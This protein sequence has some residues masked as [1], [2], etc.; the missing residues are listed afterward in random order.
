VRTYNLADLFEI[1]AAVVP[2]RLALVAGDVRLTYRDLDERASRLA[3]ALSDRGIA[4]GEHVAILSYNRAEWIEAMLAAYKI[5][6]VPINVNYRYVADELHYVLENSDSVAVVHEPEFAPVLQEIAPRVKG[7]KLSVEIGAEY[8]AIIASARSEGSPS[9]RSSDDHYIL[10]TGGTTGLPKG[11]VWRHEDIFFGALGGGGFGLNPITT[12]EELAGRAL[13]EEVRMLPLLTAPMMH[14]GGQWVSMITFYG[15]GTVVLYTGHRFDPD[16]IWR[17]VERE[18]CNQVMVVGDA[19]ARPLAEALEGGRYDAS[20]VLVI[21]SGGAILSESVRA[22]LLK[23]LPN[24]TIWDGFGTSETGAAGQIV[25][26]AGEGPKLSANPNLSVLDDEL[27][28]ATPGVI[29]RVARKGYIPLAYY[30]DEAKTASTF[31]TDAD[32]TR[33]ALPG[34][35]G[36]VT[37]DGS[38]RFLGRGSQT[39]NTGGEKVFPEEVE[40]VLK[41]HRDVFDAVVVGVPDERFVERVA[42]VV[43]ARAGAEPLLEH[44]Q[45]HCRQSLAGYKIPRQLILVD[46]IERTPAGKPDYRWAK[47]VAISTPARVRT[48]RR[49]ARRS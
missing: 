49:A 30:K 17:I 19:M 36:M 5:P 35:M 39:I 12:P 42:A 34:D 23:N 15:G 44:L 40:A 43:C 25:E 48:S 9:R 45:E 10:Y 29:G 31:V 13:P 47:E 22:Q 2:D 18:R 38:I 14:G 41:S 16:E 24:A 28:P 21:G 20:S 46:E 26:A 37:G 3:A 33:W 32:G 8:E 7:M 4:R 6:A 11:V 1:M 27:R